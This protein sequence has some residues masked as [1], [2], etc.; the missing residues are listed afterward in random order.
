MATETFSVSATHTLTPVTK[1]RVGDLIH[2]PGRGVYRRVI[3]RG[4]VRR[5]FLFSHYDE[6]RV[7]LSDGS[8]LTARDGGQRVLRR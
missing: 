1:L 5:R 3:R 7:V 2:E 8:Y 6:L 4:N